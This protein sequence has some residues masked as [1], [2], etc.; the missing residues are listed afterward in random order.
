MRIIGN[1]RGFTLIELLVVVAIIGILTALLMPAVQSA[2]ESARRAQC[3]NNLKQ[4]GLAMHNYESAFRKFPPG[5]INSYV[6]NPGPPWPTTYGYGICWG[7]YAQMLPFFERGNDFGS[8]N[9]QLAPDID[10]N[11]VGPNTTVSQN[12]MGFLICPSDPTP[13]VQ[14]QTSYGMHNYLLCTGTQYNMAQDISKWP[15]AGAPAAGFPGWS[16]RPNGVFFENSNVT[17]GVIIDG[18]YSTIAVSE[19]WRSNPFIPNPVWGAT[20]GASYADPLNGF[21]ITGNNSTTGPPIWDY[22]SY[23]SKCG[24]GSAWNPPTVPAG[25]QVTRGSKWHYGAPGHSMYNHLRPPND[26]NVDCRG[27]LPHSNKSN[28]APGY[29]WGSL[30]LN[31]TA[32]S[33]HAGGVHSLFCDGHV[34]FVRNE[35]NLAVWQALATTNGREVIDDDDFVQ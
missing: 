18:L 8:F 17:P 7:A 20:Y 10:V 30:S 21:S 3:I 34:S 25:Q 26:L 29:W 1:R 14:A 32:R 5:R 33:Y 2:R 28:V 35:I 4:I 23:S 31:I 16:A 24:V 22:T 19:T 9:F 6:N 12:F 11:G 13:D 27:G 15:P